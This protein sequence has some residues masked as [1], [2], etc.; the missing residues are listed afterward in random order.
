MQGT[1]SQFGLLASLYLYCI[2]FDYKING[3]LCSSKRFLHLISRRERNRSSS[4][5]QQPRQFSIKLS[6]YHCYGLNSPRAILFCQLK[7]TIRLRL[8]TEWP[9]QNNTAVQSHLR[10]SLATRKAGSVISSPA[11]IET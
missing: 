9:D 7:L 6:C 11:T 4:A 3:W 5:A 2:E 1:H 10:P 8:F